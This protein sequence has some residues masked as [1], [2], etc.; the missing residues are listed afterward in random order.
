VKTLSCDYGVDAIKKISFELEGVSS[1]KVFFVQKRKSADGNGETTEHQIP[2]FE[3]ERAKDSKDAVRSLTFA[4]PL[5]LFLFPYYQFV[6]EYMPSNAVDYCTY[7][8]LFR[9]RIQA[10]VSLNYEQTENCQ[11]EAKLL[12]ANRDQ[13][14]LIKPK[15]RLMKGRKNDKNLVT[16][17][18]DF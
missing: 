4:E 5:P 18:T 11:H 17:K 13:N 1:I 8:T 6:I 10:Y 9:P 12:L 3:Y 16:I 15:L 14:L 7:E 2:I